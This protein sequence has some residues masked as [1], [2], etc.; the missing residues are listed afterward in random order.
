MHGRVRSD[1]HRSRRLVSS[2]ALTNDFAAVGTRVAF[3]RAKG[4]AQAGDVEA[5]PAAG[6]AHGFSGVVLLLAISKDGG[7]CGE[8]DQGLETDGTFFRSVGHDVFHFPNRHRVRA[9]G[10]RRQVFHNDSAATTLGWWIAHCSS[11]RRCGWCMAAKGTEHGCCWCCCSAAMVLAPL[12]VV[13]PT[14]LFMAQGGVL[15]HGADAAQYRNLVA[16][17]VHGLRVRAARRS[18][19]VVDDRRRQRAPLWGGAGKGSGSTWLARRERA[20]QHHVV[21]RVTLF[22]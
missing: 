4:T 15:W 12:I 8:S 20:F 10:F 16:L 19:R 3:A 18:R 2:G 7:R 6:E 9:K 1:G 5:V 21:A 22:Y 13:G 17:H 14:E 11:R